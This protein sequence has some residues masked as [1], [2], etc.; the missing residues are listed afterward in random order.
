MLATRLRRFEEVLAAWLLML[1]GLGVAV[2]S[3]A[4]IYS[5]FMRFVVLKPQG[6]SEEFPNYLLIWSSLLAAAV[7]VARDSHLVAGMLPLLLPGRGA[8]R[9]VGV[10]SGLV[11]LGFVLVVAKAGWALAWMTM[12]QLTSALQI[13][14]GLVYLSVPVSFAAM[15]LL[16]ASRLVR[17]IL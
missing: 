1:A 15:A 6:W 8:R 9:V 3:A 2:F 4:V 16:L 12:G 10:L 7:C 5:V 14:Y 17:S 11:T 13:P